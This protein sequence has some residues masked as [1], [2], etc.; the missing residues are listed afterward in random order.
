MTTLTIQ[1]ANTK[2]DKDILAIKQM[3]QNLDEKVKNLFSE[4][5]K[6][7]KKYP[8][9]KKVDPTNNGNNNDGE[10]EEAESEAFIKQALE[11]LDS[12]LNDNIL[13]IATKNPIE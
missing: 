5:E 3:N 11:D 10:S 6:I 9:V 4:K 13:N 8:E 7:Y 12:S 2:I 1:Q